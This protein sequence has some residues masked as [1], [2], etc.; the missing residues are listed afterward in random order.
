LEVFVSFRSFTLTE[1]VRDMPGLQEATKH[2]GLALLERRGKAP[3]VVVRSDLMLQMLCVANQM[4]RF[5]SDP[6][7]AHLVR[8]TGMFSPAVAALNDE[9]LAQPDWLPNTLAELQ[10]LIDRTVFANVRQRL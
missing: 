1:V 4:Q 7:I 3:L 9:T 8:A 6:T 2:D 10:A 5:L